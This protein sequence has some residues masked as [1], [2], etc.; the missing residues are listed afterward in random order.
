M[1]HMP[2]WTLWVGVHRAYIKKDDSETTSPG[3]GWEFGC[4]VQLQGLGFRALGL[5]KVGV[6]SP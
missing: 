4:T 3:F 2:T 1:A 5:D 6:P